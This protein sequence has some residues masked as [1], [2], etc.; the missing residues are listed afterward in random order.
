MGCRLDT[1]WP[2]YKEEHYPTNTKRCFYRVRIKKSAGGATPA[3]LFI[4]SGF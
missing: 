1:W 3:Q 2:S 4:I